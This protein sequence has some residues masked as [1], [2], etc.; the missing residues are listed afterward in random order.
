MTS[1]KEVERDAS[2]CLQRHRAF[3][4]AP[5]STST[6][7]IR[8]H[9]VLDAVAELVVQATKRHG[10]AAQVEIESVLLKQFTIFQFQ[11]LSSRRFQRGFD[12][13]SLH[14]PTMAKA[15]TGDTG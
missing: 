11:A 13:V 5:V 10:V 15:C 14:R 8:R 6:S 9:Q 3:A 2:A 7:K 1:K 12:R 4:K